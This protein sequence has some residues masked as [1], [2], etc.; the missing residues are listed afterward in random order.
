MK[1]RILYG[2]GVNDADY[3]TTRSEVLG[4]KYTQVW[5]CPYYD[6]WKGMLKRCYSV[7]FK[8]KNTTYNDVVCCDEWLIFSNFKSWM[9]TQDW[10]GKELD[11]DLLSGQTKIYS[12]NTCCFLNKEEN[13]FIKIQGRK[14]ENKLPIGV[15]RKRGK[16]IFQAKISIFHNGKGSLVNLGT[17]PTAMEA[18]RAWQAAKIERSFYFARLQKDERIAEGF[19]NFSNRIQ[20]DID[21]KTETKI[22]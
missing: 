3:P 4:G 16:D 6:R 5:V 11:K 14:S 2:V 13:S 21:A 12:P 1:S 18:H 10:E 20:K 9:E 15:E 19:I 17:Y 7:K 8:Q 22:N